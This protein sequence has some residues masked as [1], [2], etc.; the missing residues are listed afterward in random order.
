MTTELLSQRPATP[1]MMAIEPPEAAHPVLVLEKPESVQL[2]AKE[3]ARQMAPLRPEIKAEVDRQLGDYVRALMEGDPNSDAFRDKIDQAYALGNE[4][5]A[6]ASTITNRF[7]KQRMA[8]L[9]STHAYAAV[10]KLRGMFEELNPARAGDLFTPVKVLGIPVPFANKLRA[11]LRKYE[12]AEKQM[13]DITSEVTL[14]QEE[15]G[16]DVAALREAERQ[17]YDAVQKLSGAEA[18]MEGLDAEISRRI[19]ALRVNDPERARAFEQEVLYYVRKNLENV[20]TVKGVTIGSLLTARETQKT[21][22]EMMR[23]CGE[24]ATIG[25][26]VLS[27]AVTFA[28]ATGNQIAVKTMLDAGK[29]TIGDLLESNARAFHTFATHMATD[30]GPVVQAKQLQ[31]YFDQVLSAADILDKYRTEALETSKTNIQLIQ[32]ASGVAMRRVE[33]QMNLPRVADVKALDL[34]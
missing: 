29:S 30:T 25:R 23:G 33:A 20:V 18:F 26:A 21:G 32:Q 9:E 3:T 34:G 2:P 16:R 22:R 5:I 31:N 12:S 4:Q 6:Q 8:G 15:I 13:D 17:F 11:Y 19:D 27:Q 28:R 10:S 24:M 14:A 7:T 1:P